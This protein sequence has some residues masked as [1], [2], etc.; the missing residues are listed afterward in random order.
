M[1]TF[2]KI[3]ANSIDR[4]F[5]LLYVFFAILVVSPLGL[6]MIVP[7]PGHCLFHLL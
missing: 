3:A 1:A 4:I 5:S 2:W 6:V 7:V